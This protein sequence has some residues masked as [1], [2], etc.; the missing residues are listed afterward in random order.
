MKVAPFDMCPKWNQLT[1]AQFLPA[2]VLEVWV[3]FLFLCWSQAWEVTLPA[4]CHPVGVHCNPIEHSGI[5]FPYKMLQ[6]IKFIRM[7]CHYFCIIIQLL[8]LWKVINHY[9]GD[10]LRSWEGQLFSQIK[11]L[12]PLTRCGDLVLK[13]LKSVLWSCKV[14]VGKPSTSESRP[15]PLPRPPKS[16]TLS[17]APKMRVPVSLFDDLEREH[18]KTENQIP[19]RLH[20]TGSTENAQT[21]YSLIIHFFSEKACVIICAYMC[22]STHALNCLSIKL[23]LQNL[24]VH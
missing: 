1:L 21:A 9:T 15:N 8:E 6:V 10:K 13:L 7:A 17:T 4:S 22:M 20:F 23:S 2:S 5:Q 16:L 11:Q 18:R 24:L 14:S 19:T 12:P 3:L